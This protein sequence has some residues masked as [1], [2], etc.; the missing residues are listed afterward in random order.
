MPQDWAKANELLLKAGELGCA[1]AYFRL[2]YSFSNGMGVETDKKKAKHYYEIAAMKG[3][4][5]ARHNLGCIEGNAGNHQRAFK[6]FIL[7]A[8]AGG[9]NSLDR[10]KKGFMD[11]DVQ[12]MNMKALYAHIMNVKLR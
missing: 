6:H 2:G 3:N 9:K 8:R 11:G 5:K 1:E 7:A 10:V 4:V 12:K